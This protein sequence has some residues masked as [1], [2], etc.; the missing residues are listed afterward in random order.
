MAYIV[1]HAEKQNNLTSMPHHI[2]RI[3]AYQE[4]GSVTV[5]PDDYVDETLRGKSKHPQIKYPERYKWN[6]GGGATFAEFSKRWLEEIVRLERSPQKNASPTVCFNNSAGEEFWE[7]LRKAYPKDEDYYSKCEEYFYDCRVVLDELYPYGKTL[8]WATHY[9]EK[10][11]HMHC[12][13]IPIVKAPKRLSK[14]DIA[15][16]KKPGEAILK[17]SSGEFLGGREGLAKLQD[18]IFEK[19]GKKWGLERGERGSDARHTDQV[20]WQR[21]LSL[22][23]KELTAGLKMINEIKEKNNRDSEEIAA[24]KAKIKK[25]ESEAISEKERLITE[26]QEK[27]KRLIEEGQKEAARIRKEAEDEAKNKTELIRK[28]EEAVERREKDVSSRELFVKGAEEAIIGMKKKLSG[29]DKIGVSVLEVL[30]A[31][32]VRGEE[33]K[34]FFNEFFRKIP[35]FVR[36]IIKTIRKPPVKKTNKGEIKT[37]TNEKDGKEHKGWS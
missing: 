37:Q 33:R 9:E 22:K 27:Q 35:D 6:K 18:A 8:K 32:S 20:E 13:K 36:D 3:G 11:P 21:E 34:K 24:L 31:E 12:L 30:N 28:S 5:Y 19:V 2:D 7:E 29:E 4:D 26:G 15:A 17:F 1:C 23:D 25:Q 14:K 10:E 16:E